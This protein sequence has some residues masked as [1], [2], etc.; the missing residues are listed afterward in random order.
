M[1]SFA[2][3]Q[4][5]DWKNKASLLKNTVT[6]AVGTWQCCVCWTVTAYRVTYRLG[7][8]SHP[9]VSIPAYFHIWRQWGR[10]S[11]GRNYVRYRVSLSINVSSGEI[12]KRV[13]RHNSNR[14]FKH[15]AIKHGCRVQ[16]IAPHCVCNRLR[17]KNFPSVS[18]ENCQFVL[19]LFDPRLMHQLCT[20][21]TPKKLWRL[22]DTKV[23]A[24]T[25]LA[26]A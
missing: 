20:P 22:N 13:A 8:V 11:A 2:L 7:H 10:Q 16:W 18:I 24:A 4:A 1:G 12:Q 5:G 6:A 15:D 21:Q 23:R 19:S 26:F 17:M 14:K 3:S 9:D 25:L